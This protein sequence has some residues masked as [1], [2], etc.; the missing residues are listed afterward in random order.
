MAVP[1]LELACMTLLDRR[2]CSPPCR[3]RACCRRPGLGRNPV[4]AGLQIG[5]GRGRF[6]FDGLR[7]RAKKLAEP[8]YQ[9]PPSRPPRPS[10]RASIST[11]SRRSGSAPK[12]PCGAAWPGPIRLLFPSQQIF[13]RSGGH[14]RPADPADGK[15]VAREF[16][17]CSDYFDY[18]D[19]RPRSQAAGQAGL[20]RLPGDGRPD[21]SRPTGWPSRAPAISAPPARTVNMA[22]PPAA[23]PSTPPPPTRGRISPLHPILAGGKRA[24]RS[25]IYALLDGPSRHR[26]L[27]IRLREDTKQAA[28]W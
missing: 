7:D 4:A 26:R 24:R 10:S 22:P 25:T 1:A 13:R 6:T 27:P 28:R 19:S 11:R 16:V 14:F 20:R 18:G 23:S 12:T 15:Q 17:Y 5:A 3:L 9:A 2:C 21:H 8:A